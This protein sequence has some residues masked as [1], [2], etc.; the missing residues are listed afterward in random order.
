MPF[1]LKSHLEKTRPAGQ[2]TGGTPQTAAEQRSNLL[3]ILKR[4]DWAMLSK[5]RYHMS[6][7]YILQPV[8]HHCHWR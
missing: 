5:A 6:A 4:G 3:I 7:S 8:P 2:L 1:H